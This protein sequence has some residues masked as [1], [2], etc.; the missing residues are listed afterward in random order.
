[1]TALQPGDEVIAWSRDSRAV[2]VQR[3]LAVPVRVERVALDVPVRT[4]AR[5]ISP[6]DA[7]P[8]T[9][10]YVTDWIDDG[11]GFVYNYTTQPS[12]L[13]VVKGVSE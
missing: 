7:G 4:L 2:Y 5:E 13:F 12:T 9:M 1:V 3:G 11:E 6:Q 8:I 10:L